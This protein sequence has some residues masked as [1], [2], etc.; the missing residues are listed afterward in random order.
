MSNQTEGHIP[1]DS[2]STPA[3]PVAAEAGGESRPHLEL[4]ARAIGGTVTGG[5]VQ[6]IIRFS[7]QHRLL[8][9]GIKRASDIPVVKEEG[10][11][12]LTPEGGSV[13]FWAKGTGIF[14]SSTPVPDSSMWMFDT[15]FFHY[16]SSYN[17]DG[18]ATMAFAITDVDRLLMSG[19]APTITSD[20]CTIAEAVNP[21]LLTVLTAESA[22]RQNVQSAVF[23]FLLAG[24]RSEKLL[25]SGVQDI[26]A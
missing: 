2:Y 14:F 13:S 8:F 24:V 21:A 9:H 23:D 15:P 4:V 11:L 6:E 3:I 20:T 5:E 19:I 22:N 18:P 17:P 25:L 26:K 16:G 12:P 1:E 7:E 10:V